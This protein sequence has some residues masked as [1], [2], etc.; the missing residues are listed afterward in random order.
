MIMRATRCTPGR[1][2]VLQDAGRCNIRNQIGR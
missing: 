2:D 1:L